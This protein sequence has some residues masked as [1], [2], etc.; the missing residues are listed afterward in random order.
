MTAN[1]HF[2]TGTRQQLN[3]KLFEQIGL[4]RR[5]VFIDRLG[6]ELE[7][8]N[9]MEMDE[10]DGPDAIYV[11]A[12]DEDENVSGVARLLPTTA[13]YLMEKVFPELWASKEL[14][15]D[16][17]IWELSRFAAVNPTALPS[18]AHQASAHH[19]AALF[20]NV[21][22]ECRALGASTLI[23]VSPVGMERLLRSHGVRTMRAGV[24]IM[25]HGTPIV[26]L[27]IQ[28]T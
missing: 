11:C 5:E 10:F 8:I 13:P 26:S 14:P 27:Q 12:H 4:Y 23:T 17:A 9:G 16:E 6:W 15:H 25:N 28:C 24:P 19:A 2:S 18:F 21:M 22:T 7:S 1:L 3:P 20:W